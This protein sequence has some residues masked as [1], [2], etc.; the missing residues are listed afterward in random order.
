MELQ[1]AIAQS[2]LPAYQQLVLEAPSMMERVA[3]EVLIQALWADC[4]RQL[5]RC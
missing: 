3:G 1:Q 2:I 5:D 4:L